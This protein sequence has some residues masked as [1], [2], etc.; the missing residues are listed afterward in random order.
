MIYARSI[1]SIILGFSPKKAKIY[2]S[3]FT[4]GF[5]IPLAFIITRSRAGKLQAD[6]IRLKPVDLQYTILANFT[7]EYPVPLEMKFF[8]EGT[9][10]AIKVK[11]GD[12]LTKGQIIIELDDF[13]AR[14]EYIIS[15]KELEVAEIKLKNAREE[16]LPKLGEKL[17]KLEAD[18]A[19]A[20]L[21]I[22]RYRK[23]EKEGGIT[24][25]QLE[26]VENDYLRASSE[27]NQTRLEIDSFTRSGMI[28]NLEN[29]VASPNP[30]AGE[31]NQRNAAANY[32]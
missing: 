10:K 14:Q 18:L 30:E 2:L 4:L 27:Y 28:P 6:F 19:Q 1:K 15:Q 13:K 7:V 8:Q 25:A 26:K 17:K 29:Q 21:M 5:L 32:L 20:E 23:L 24:R 11:E 16:I 9:V 12:E 22:K 3:F 31:R